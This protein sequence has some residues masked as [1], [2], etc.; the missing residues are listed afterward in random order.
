MKRYNLIILASLI[1]ALLFSVACAPH[2]EVAL[3]S[4]PEPIITATAVPTVTPTPT[5]S[6]V[7][8]PTP[9]F[10]EERMAELNQQMLDFLN[11]EGEFTQEKIASMMMQFYT[12]NEIDYYE[13]FKTDTVGL[14]ISEHQPLIQGYLFDY[15][16][17]EGRLILIF[18]FDGRDGNRFITPVEI[19]IYIYDCFE[20]AEFRVV[21][22]FVNNI[23][24]IDYYSDSD[25]QEYDYERMD[26][27]D[28]NLLLP[29]LDSLKSKV[30]AFSLYYYVY[31]NK[32]GLPYDE[33]SRI[34]SEFQDETNSKNDLSYGLVQLLTSNDIEY[35]WED[36][37][38][39]SDSIIKI[40][41]SDDINNIN[42][43]DVPIMES[44]KYFEGALIENVQITPNS[45]Y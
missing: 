25:E 31:D 14:G 10:S 24:C 5:L 40:K 8:T 18:G 27:S 4:T 13:H 44:I 23:D 7:P 17:V 36:R 19:P 16:E 30:F 26:C 2:A 35:D 12:G 22:S 45:S 37:I 34:I 1:V 42:I 43:S 21:K 41:N 3:T 15:F 39:D 29:L 33:L 20:P 9:I 11:R 38:G 6:P 28:R 32:G